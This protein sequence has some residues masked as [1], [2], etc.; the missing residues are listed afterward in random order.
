MIER[1]GNGN[2]MPDWAAL[3]SL[4]GWVHASLGQVAP[5]LV[6]RVLSM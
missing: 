3:W 2:F 1:I 6:V 4:V 5:G